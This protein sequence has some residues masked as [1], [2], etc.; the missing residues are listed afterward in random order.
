MAKGHAPVDT[1]RKLNV[2]QT[3]KRGLIYVQ[4]TS[5]VCRGSFIHFCEK[6][7]NKTCSEV[8]AGQYKYCC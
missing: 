7:L 2:H 5:C 1:G 8:V 6:G 3:F 4:F